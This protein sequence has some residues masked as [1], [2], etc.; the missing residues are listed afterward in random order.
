M[1]QPGDRAQHWCSNAWARTQGNSGQS[2]AG[3]TISWEHHAARGQQHPSHVGSFWM[4]C[5]GRRRCQRAD[6][7]GMLH[8]VP[9]L[10]FFFSVVLVYSFP[11]FS[12]SIVLSARQRQIALSS[13]RR[14]L[15]L[16]ESHLC[17]G[18]SLK[19]RIR[20]FPLGGNITNSI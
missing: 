13:S 19:T 9:V 8:Q 16:V 20:L 6:S 3:S 17:E 4:P 10:T 14:T 11:F 7:S 2:K 12:A 15:N 5:H 1:A 18:I